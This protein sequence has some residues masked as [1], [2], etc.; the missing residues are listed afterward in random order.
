MILEKGYPN[1]SPSLREEVTVGCD[2]S[3]KI[4]IWLDLSPWP[5]KISADTYKQTLAEWTMWQNVNTGGGDLLEWWEENFKYTL[6][7]ELLGSAPAKK[8]S[9]WARLSTSPLR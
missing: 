2:Q 3:Y 1:H 9:R 5:E 7:Q 4:E 6:T 8:P